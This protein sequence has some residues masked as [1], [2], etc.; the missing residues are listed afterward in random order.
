MTE[1]LVED[2]IGEQRAIRL[3]HDDIAAARLHWPGR[4]TAGQIEDAQ[5]IARHTGSPRGTARFASGEQA[6]VDR[7]PKS[8]SEGAMLR[9]QVVRAAIGEKGRTKLAHARHTDAAPCPAPDLATALAAEGHSVRRVHRFPGSGWD[10]LISEALDGTIAFDGGSLH[11]SPTPAMTLI[12]ID[13]ALPPPALALAAVPAIVGALQRFDLA[14]SIGIDFPTLPEKAD[15]RAVD[16]ALEQ[17][18]S[19]WAHERTAINGFGF[20][21]IVARLERPSLLHRAARQPGAMAARRLLRQAE[22]ISD[23]GALLLTCPP[24]VKAHLSDPLLSELAR[25]SGRE[26]RLNDNPALAP[27]GSFAQAVPL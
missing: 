16:A 9:L 15:R 19:G 21:Q 23:P 8:A 14:G 6:L 4:L 17:A 24:A 10:D 12:D 27:G 1:W 18:L 20:L 11:L 13:G 2:G 5:L 26:I 22:A 7:L 25:R 3:V